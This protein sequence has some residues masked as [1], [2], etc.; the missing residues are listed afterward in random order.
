MID[1]NSLGLEEEE[2]TEGKQVK[3][4]NQ[5]LK[6][7]FYLITILDRISVQEN[8]IVQGLPF[9]VMLKLAI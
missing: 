8:S 2:E 4:R 9:L 7:L 6:C 5:V 1:L 3:L